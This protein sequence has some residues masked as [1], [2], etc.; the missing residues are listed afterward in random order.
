MARPERSEHFLILL[1]ERLVFLNAFVDKTLVDAIVA[2]CL[3]AGLDVHA[4]SIAREAGRWI[5]FYRGE[6]ISKPQFLGLSLTI[7]DADQRI[8]ADAWCRADGDHFFYGDVYVVVGL[9]LG[10]SLAPAHI[11]QKIRPE[12]RQL[13]AVIKRAVDT[14]LWVSP[15]YNNPEQP[16]AVASIISLSRLLGTERTAVLSEAASR[17]F[18]AYRQRELP[19]GS[20]GHVS[21]NDVRRARCLEWDMSDEIAAFV[22]A[23]CLRKHNHVVLWWNADI[24]CV[25]CPLAVALDYLGAACDASS[26]GRCT[27]FGVSL[28]PSGMVFDFASFLEA[29]APNRHIVATAESA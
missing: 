2:R 24:P 19:I 29:D 1:S 15:G 13:A 25:F 8:A 5:S 26:S 6:I 28:E 7:E 22:Q 12:H 9:L 21:W 17:A 27:L 23:T 14:H 18:A 20:D 3:A 16:V 10:P 4:C 11:S